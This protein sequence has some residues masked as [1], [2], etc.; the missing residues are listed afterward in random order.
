VTVGS[1]AVN[2]LASST[3]APETLPSGL[4]VYPTKLG[5]NG[6]EIAPFYYGSFTATQLGY[7]G[8]QLSTV[9][10]GMTSTG[11]VLA[12][13]FTSPSTLIELP[14]RYVINIEP[15]TDCCTFYLSDNISVYDK[16]TWF[17]PSLGTGPYA[18][19][20]PAEEPPALESV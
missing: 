3:D 20:P 10:T 11:T 14:P 16:V 7:G 5:F 15:A 13:Y 18:E 17:S 1:G 2:I 19:P 8:T 4:S 9:I 12:Q 6:A